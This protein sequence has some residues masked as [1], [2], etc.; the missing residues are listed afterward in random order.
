MADELEPLA[1]GQLEID[2]FKRKEIRKVFHENEWY[3]SI[4]D[5][6]EAITETTQPRRYWAE[7]KKKL[8]Q[9]G[10]DQLLDKIEQLKIASSDGKLYATDAAN[11]ETVFRLIQSISSAKAEP[12]KRWLARV[13]YERIQEFHDPEIG[14]KRAMADYLAKGY[15]W[16]WIN[17]RLRTISSRKELTSEWARRGVREG[18]EY[19]MLTNVISKETFNLDTQQHANYKGLAKQNLR[20]HMTDLEL[21]L[22]ALGEKSTTELARARDAKGF[23]Q[24]E[25]TAH[26][27]GR[28]AGDARKNLEKQLGHTVVSRRNFL[29]KRGDQGQL[30]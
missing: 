21:I 20:D 23:D 15:T 1:E 19:A 13:G 14:L 24:N 5:V 10:G 22:T 17:A 4:V 12:F 6:I 8:A 27:G 11:T 7:L 16:E 30:S 2:L 18:M 28:I 25:D 29:P 26:A 9:E 3:F